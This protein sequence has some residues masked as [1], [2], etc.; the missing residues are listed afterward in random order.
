MTAGSPALTTLPAS[1]PARALPVALAAAT[2]LAQIAYPLVSGTARDRLTIVTVVLFFAAS[3]SHAAVWRGPRFAGALVGVAA[4][5][6]L[7]VEAFG[8]ATGLPFGAYAYADSLGPKV[9]GV[10]VVI[11]LAWAMMAYPALLVGG[12][13][14]PSPRWVALCAGAALATWDLFLDPQMVDAG[15]WVWTGGS[16]PTLLEVPLLNFLAWFLVATAMMA[17]LARVP[18]RREPPADDRVPFA[19]YLWTYASSVLA[20]AAFFG[21][22]GSALLGGI[23]MGAVVALFILR[24]R[25]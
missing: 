14:A 20:H 23:G 18:S 4:G 7:L 11:P 5:G 19:L 24:S 22:P 15:H 3:T 9:A 10:P 6:G 2:I 25:R 13:I 1:R 21:L 16:G 12:R 17:A 8:V